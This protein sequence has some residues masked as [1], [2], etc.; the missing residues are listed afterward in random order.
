MRNAYVI[1]LIILFSVPIVIA[2][3]NATIDLCEGTICEDS[4]ATCPDGF[5]AA[6]GNSC[7]PETGACSECTPDCEGH[8]TV[9][10]CSGV[11]CGTIETVC[12]DGFVATCEK[13]CIPDT[14]E[15]AECMASCEGHEPTIVC[16]AGDF[17]CDGNLIQKC[18]DPH[19]GFVTVN[20]CIYGEECVIEGDNAFCKKLSECG[21]GFCETGEDEYNCHDDCTSTGEPFCGDGICQGDEE[22]FCE[23][24]CMIPPKTDCPVSHICP[25]GSHAICKQTEEGCICEECPFVEI[26][27]NCH[28]EIDEFGHIRIVC[29]RDPVCP[30][31][32]E[33]EI[34]KCKRIGGEPVFRRDPSG[35]EVFACEFAKSG[36]NPFDTQICP[37]PHEVDEAMRQCEMHGLKPVLAFE[38][39][40]K[41]PR[42]IEHEERKCPIITETEFKE[43]ER[44]CSEGDLDVIK[45]FRDGCTVLSCGDKDSCPREP[46][47]DF[48]EKCSIEGGEI[49]VKHGPNGCIEFMECISRASHKEAY[50]EQP[51]EV[52]TTNLLEIALKLEQLRVEFDKLAR[53]A[54]NIADYYYSTGSPESERFERI[55]DMFE[56]AEDKVDEIKG[57]IRSRVERATIDDMIEIKHEIHYL[58][59]V[60][61]KDILYI[62]LSDGEDVRDIKE[63]LQS[64]CGMDGECFDRAFRVCKPI[65]FEPEGREGPFVTI[66]GLENG[67]CVMHAIME[68][69]PREGLPPGVSLPIEMTCHVTKYALGLRGPEDIIHECEGSMAD[70]F[71]KYGTG[72]DGP[73]APGVPG[74]C[75]GG[76]C[77]RY[78]GTSPEAA[79]ECLDHLGPYL[80]PEAIEPLTRLSRGEA[81]FG[82]RDEF[83]R[84][85]F[86]ERE[87]FRSTEEY[88]QEYREEH[89]EECRDSTDCPAVR[90][91][92]SQHSCPASACVNG[93]CVVINIQQSDI[94]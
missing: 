27:P 89:R 8:E 64:E 13:K 76:E 25:D 63:G 72:K 38:G 67:K 48:I 20:K 90:E 68:E 44:S 34:D 9:D 3:N 66:R 65:T 79:Q 14:G 51:K 29:E 91:P 15:C 52:D 28:Q 6:C 77:E 33:E 60:I 78:C 84:R 75:Y 56:A 42:C 80:P 4:V 35:C 59:D 31:P 57:F 24:D 62:M 46:P 70:M 30:H 85:D 55:A 82:P 86:P 40:C 7:D 71:N 81:F 87:E 94:R 32:P 61:L 18:E 19:E 36:R 83:E 43:V 41:V 39:N 74:K 23:D 2:Q 93:K 50:I 88:R 54:Q 12:E 47:E 16:E 21:N 5:E 37:P 58:K 11:Q 45:I 10:L 22:H 17:R 1:A 92:C 73:G 49:A 26:P 53:E 69:E